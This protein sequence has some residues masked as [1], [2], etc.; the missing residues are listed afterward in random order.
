[1]PDG[2]ENPLGARALN[3]LRGDVDTL[4]RI[5]GTTQPQSIGTA[6]S[7]GCLRLINSD[8]SELC[9]RVEV[10]AK[11]VVVS[12]PLFT[13]VCRHHTC[14][15]LWQT[16]GGRNA[17]HFEWFDVL[18]AGLAIAH[19]VGGSDGHVVHRARAWGI[20]RLGASD[21]LSHIG[22]RLGQSTDPDCMGH[23]CCIDHRQYLYP[24][25]VGNRLKLHIVPAFIGAIGGIIAF[26]AADLILGPAIVSV[27]LALIK[28]L[29]KRFSKVVVMLP[30]P[31][32]ASRQFYNWDS[33]GSMPTS[34]ASSRRA[35]L[36]SGS[37]VRSLPSE[38]L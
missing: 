4:Y 13:K 32:S 5:H 28:I 14:N 20:C 2:L 27:T 30:S 12:K 38:L 23:W 15:G 3:L 1:M 18:V 31:V 34:C 26:G 19:I 17:G 33:M 29:K 22:R 24:M 8:I 9:D 21:Y 6:T 16:C 10:G 7:P 35:K 25:L 36:V 11:V 37:W